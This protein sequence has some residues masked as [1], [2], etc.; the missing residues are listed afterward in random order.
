M[1]VTL[2]PMSANTGM[3]V[4]GIDLREPVGEQA[5]LEMRHA[6]CDTGVICFRGQELS[7]AH[8]L[9]FAR[10]FG[11]VPPAEFLTTPD[12]FPEIGI[13]GKEPDQT[14]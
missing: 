13:V 8:H 2:R 11:A 10:R 12:G 9:A 1:S 3:E 4:S 14:R 6:L 5:Y 7:P